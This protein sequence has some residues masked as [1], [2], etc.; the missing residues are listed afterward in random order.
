MMKKENKE[1]EKLGWRKYK[2]SEM[3]YK[4]SECFYQKIF[5]MNGD[6]VSVEIAQYDS[7]VARDIKKAWELHVYIPEEI[8]IVGKTIRVI[9][10]SYNKLN[11]REIERD[12]L[13]IMK[14]LVKNL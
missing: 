12:A 10:Y 6:K 14:G 13:K 7:D 1:Y 5:E 8:S 9:S 2:P 11:F 4:Y 3:V